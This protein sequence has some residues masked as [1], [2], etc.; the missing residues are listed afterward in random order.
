MGAMSHLVEEGEGWFDADLV[1]SGVIPI[2]FI[3]DD[4]AHPAFHQAPR[5]DSDPRR[6]S[7]PSSHS[8]TS[9]GCMLARH[10]SR[11]VS[12]SDGTEDFC[13]PQLH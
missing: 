11:R 1:L 5:F 8:T 12:A 9:M 7:L 4:D 6:P 3:R 10:S 13:H 2:V